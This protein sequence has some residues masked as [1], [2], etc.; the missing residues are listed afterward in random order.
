MPPQTISPVTGRPRPRLARGVSEGGEN[1]AKSLLQEFEEQLWSQAEILMRRRGSYT[2]DEAD[3]ADGYD[4]LIRPRRKAVIRDFI[5]TL[6]VM[7]GAALLGYGINLLTSTPQPDGAWLA[8]ICG[9]V[10]G[11]LG[12]LFR[13]WDFG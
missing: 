4:L 11:G 3:F 9:G 13:H 2:L 5:A 8:V 6:I 1:Q 10:I 12:E 7:V